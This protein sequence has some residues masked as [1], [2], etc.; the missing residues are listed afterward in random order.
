MCE[1]EIED[2]DRKNEGGLGQGQNLSK[3]AWAR[4]PGPGDK[5]YEELRDGKR[6]PCILQDIVFQRYSSS[7]QK[8]SNLEEA[9]DAKGVIFKQNAFSP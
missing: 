7:R 5:I 9:A 6:I 3:E 2:H 8:A 1:K 4:K